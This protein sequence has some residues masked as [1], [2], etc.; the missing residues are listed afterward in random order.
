M[1]LNEIKKADESAFVN[2]MKTQ[3]VDGRFIVK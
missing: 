1:V 3:Q 2:I